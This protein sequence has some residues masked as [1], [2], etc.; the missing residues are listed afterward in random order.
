[1]TTP[2]TNRYSATIRCRS[3]TSILTCSSRIFARLWL[4]PGGSGYDLHPSHCAALLSSGASWHPIHIFKALCALQLWKPLIWPHRDLTTCLSAILLIMSRISRPSPVRRRPKSGVGG[5]SLECQ[6]DQRRAAHWCAYEAWAKGGRVV[7]FRAPDGSIIV[8]RDGTSPIRLA[9]I[10]RDVDSVEPRIQARTP[11]RPLELRTGAIPE[12]TLVIL[13]TVTLSFHP[14][15]A[16]PPTQLLDSAGL[17]T[18]LLA[19]AVIIGLLMLLAYR[20]ASRTDL[21]KLQ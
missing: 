16:P 8:P 9:A 7:A 14:Q 1:M 6:D 18:V 2:I 5:R 17:T 11:R 3:P 19:L 13:Q 10:D 12:S 21:A 15:V 4:A 20:R